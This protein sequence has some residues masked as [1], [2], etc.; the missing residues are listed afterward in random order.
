[1]APMVFVPKP[2]QGGET[3]GTDTGSVDKVKVIAA[4]D[5][6]AIADTLTLILNQSAVEARAVYSGE[7]AFEAVDGFEPDGHQ[8][9]CNERNEWDRGG[10]RIRALRPNCR[11]VLLFSSQAATPDVLQEARNLGTHSIIPKPHDPTQLLGRTRSI[12]ISY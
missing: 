10:Y 4:D 7:A 11:V 5:E 9:S 8:R 3:T 12:V 1:M 2:S 6:Q